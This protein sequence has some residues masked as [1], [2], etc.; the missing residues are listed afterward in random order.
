MTIELD[1]VQPSLLPPDVVTV[2]L[3]VGLAN[4]GNHVQWLV[5]ATCP[6][7]GTLLAMESCPHAPLSRLDAELAAAARRLVRLAQEHA[8]TL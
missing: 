2:T 7:D 4:S 8:W 5:Q 3:T 6:T 1:H